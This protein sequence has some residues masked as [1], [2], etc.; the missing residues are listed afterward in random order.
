MSV[1]YK[2]WDD[3]E[4][5]VTAAVAKYAKAEGE[6]ATTIARD[7][8]TGTVGEWAPDNKEDSFMYL[9]SQLDLAGA[10][11]TQRK[12]VNDRFE[13]IWADPA[14]KK[15]LTDGEMLNGW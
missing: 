1:D 12:C 3:L 4:G 2:F 10:D 8:M 7:I 9:Q 14:W 15:R 13:I 6:K 5:A 11:N